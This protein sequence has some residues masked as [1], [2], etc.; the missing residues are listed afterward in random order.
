MKTIVWLGDRQRIIDQSKLPQEEAY[1]ELASYQEVAQAIRNMNIRG[2][3]AI[4]V[5]AA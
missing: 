1:L 2:A 4:G 5:A 3:P